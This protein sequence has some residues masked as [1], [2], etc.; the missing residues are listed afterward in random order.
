MRSVDAWLPALKQSDAP[1][2]RE[3]IE[4]EHTQS[5][6]PPYESR[7]TTAKL[8]I[9]AE[10]YEVGIYVCRISFL[11]EK[12]SALYSLSLPE[13]IF[14]NRGVVFTQ[15]ARERERERVINELL[16]GG[17]F[18]TGPEAKGTTRFVCIFVVA[19]E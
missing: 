2:S 18:L 19:V 7:V 6:F 16:P 1:P 5:D 14:N 10:E 13:I 11:F 8:L 4:E 9:E 12:A 17:R 3:D 15:R